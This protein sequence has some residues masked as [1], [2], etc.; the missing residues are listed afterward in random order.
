MHYPFFSL[1]LC[2]LLYVAVCNVQDKFPSGLNKV[3]L[4]LE[5]WTPRR[6][7]AQNGLKEH[8]TTVLYM[9]VGGWELGVK[10]AEQ[11]SNNVMRVERYAEH[12]EVSVGLFK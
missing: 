1:L 6:V 10:I 12:V 5:S 11:A 9:E 2:Y 7:P 3:I 4:N 8:D